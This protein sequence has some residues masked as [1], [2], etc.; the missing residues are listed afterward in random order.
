M[1]EGQKKAAKKEKEKRQTPE[2]RLAAMRYNHMMYGPTEGEM[3]LAPK[4]INY[5]AS[6]LKHPKFQSLMTAFRNGSAFKFEILIDG[7][8]IPIATDGSHISFDGKT[9]FYSRSLNKHE[10]NLFLDRTGAVATQTNDAAVHL[11]FAV[12]KSLA[13]LGETDLLY[14][15]HKF[16]Y[17]TDILEFS[18]TEQSANLMFGTINTHKV[19]EKTKKA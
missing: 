4:K 9:L 18:T 6:Y 13:E 7:R 8:L 16:V 5:G 11:V 3:K 19:L 17:G 14:Q 12:L 1:A 2:E 10:D 15:H